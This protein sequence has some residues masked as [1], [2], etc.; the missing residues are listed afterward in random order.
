MKKSRVNKGS[1]FFSEIRMGINEKKWC[2]ICALLL[3]TILCS[4]LFDNIRGWNIAQ[5]T[6]IQLD[7]EIVCSFGDC[8]FYLF[9]GMK[10]FDPLARQPFEVPLQY[11]IFGIIP[12]FIVGNY[13]VQDIHGFGK[14]KLV[15]SQSRLSWWMG[16]CLWNF[17]SV[18]IY[19][20]SIIIGIL[21]SCLIHIKDMD[22]S[23][24]GQFIYV[25]R[26]NV[27][28]FI[29]T[30]S[31]LE[32]ENVIESIFLLEECWEQFYLHLLP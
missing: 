25:N 1:L 6:G 7:K 5:T 24:V 16:K 29:T 12:V 26:D 21:L 3:T 13:A 4:G 31:M 15:L 23:S 11:M 9:R 32:K 10:P 20:F 8:F 14:L 27:M 18:A 19:I 30:N 22:T 2:F 28:R 17:V